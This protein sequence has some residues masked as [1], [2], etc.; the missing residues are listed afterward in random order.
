MTALARA[1]LASTRRTRFAEAAR[2]CEIGQEIVK[3]TSRRVD[4]LGTD[5]GIY[6]GNNEVMMNE[7]V[8]YGGG[9]PL[10]EQQLLRDALLSLSKASTERQKLADIAASEATELHHLVELLHSADGAEKQ[11]IEARVKRLL[12]EM[13]LRNAIVPVVYPDLSRGHSAGVEGQC[14]D[15]SG[16]GAN[17]DREAG[18]GSAPEEGPQT[19]LAQAALG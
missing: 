16:D 15:P 7:G 19:G 6:L 5:G 14:D 2:I 9:R 8:N 17:A 3:A 11:T 18:D 13:E 12:A 4:D 1:T 10:D